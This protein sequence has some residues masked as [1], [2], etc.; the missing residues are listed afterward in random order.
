MD[1]LTDPTQ[2]SVTEEKGVRMKKLLLLGDGSLLQSILI[3]PFAICGLIL[4][5]RGAVLTLEELSEK[6]TFKKDWQI[7]AFFAVFLLCYLAF[8]YAITKLL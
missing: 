7:G 6:F 2:G 3:F 4:F 5:L 8:V 1:A